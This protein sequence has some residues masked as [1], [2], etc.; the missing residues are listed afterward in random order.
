M[1]SRAD[2]S[3]AGVGGHGPRHG[4][5]EADR[6]AVLDAAAVLQVRRSETAALVARRE[7][8]DVEIV[9]RGYDRI[10]PWILEATTGWREL[11][12]VRPAGDDRPAARAAFPTTVRW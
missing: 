8:P 3:T 2:R 7:L 1:E 11:L 4:I 12:S 5:P 6:Q 10:N 9:E